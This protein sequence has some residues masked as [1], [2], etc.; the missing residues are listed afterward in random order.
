M[1]SGSVSSAPTSRSP[2]G[3]CASS[4]ATMKPRLPTTP[5]RSPRPQ[6]S[7][8][9]RSG[10]PRVDPPAVSIASSTGHAPWRRRSRGSRSTSCRADLD[11]AQQDIDRD[12]P[13]E[14]ALAS[15]I[16]PAWQ[17]DASAWAVAPDRWPTSRPLGRTVR[18]RRPI[19]RE[20]PR[21]RRSQ[22]IG[23]ATGWRSSAPA[24]QASRSSIGSGWASSNP[25]P[26]NILDRYGSMYRRL[27]PVG[28]GRRPAAR[29]SSSRTG[30][31]VRSLA[32]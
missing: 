21:R 9:I 23:T 3:G 13:V 16:V 32:A 4:S 12:A 17:G 24:T 27:A 8:M 19:D 28:P 7:P 26:T 5:L 29:R 25:L 10:R 30:R 20:S 6:R 15:L 1:R 11:L 18:L 2:P 22:T 31:R 14:G